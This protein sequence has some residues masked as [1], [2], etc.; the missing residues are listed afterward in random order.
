MANNPPRPQPRPRRIP[1]ALDAIKQEFDVLQADR[2]ALR[3]QR[4]D[5]EA[6][7]ASSSSCTVSIDAVQ[8]RTSS[9]RSPTSV[10]RCMTSRSSR[11]RCGST[12]RT[13]FV[14]CASSSPLSASKAFLAFRPSPSV[15]LTVSPTHVS[16]SA[17]SQSAPHPT[18]PST[19]P[20]PYP[21]STPHVLSAGPPLPTIY[22]QYP[23]LPPFPT[24]SQSPPNLEKM[25]QTGLLS[26]ILA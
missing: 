7:G 19:R 14:V 17:P 25:A 23:P 8:S 18:P 4:D 26:S 3:A 10:A 24:T 11:A 6:K 22:L 5:L 9:T 13:S 21:L 16:P 1:D 2:D 20:T 15:T 12:T